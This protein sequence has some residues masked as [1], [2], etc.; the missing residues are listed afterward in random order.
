MATCKNC[1]SKSTNGTNF[2]KRQCRLEWIKQNE[3]T[4][5]DWKRLE[6][7]REKELDAWSSKFDSDGNSYPNN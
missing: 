4:K 5:K 1:G 2:C 7:K 3:Y 6:R